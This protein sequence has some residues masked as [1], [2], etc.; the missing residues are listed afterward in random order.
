MNNRF[1]SIIFVLL[2]VY[3]VISACA[4]TKFYTPQ[5][6]AVSY[7]LDGLPADVVFVTVN[8]LRP[9]SDNDDGLANVLKIQLSEA[10]S[11]HPSKQLTNR[12]T[13][14]VDII[15]HRSF[16]TLGNW[17]ASTRFRIRLE[18]SMGKIL[19]QWEAVGSAQHSNTWNLWGDSTAEE[20]SQ[21]S[22]NSAVSD[23]MSYLSQVT[24]H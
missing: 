2:V 17:N 19:G 6:D 22:Y 20:V 15:D 21:E 3:M 8:D 1:R 5:P 4:Q 23:M 24:V 13:V 11:L 10:F 12:Y 16:F 18:N 7:H 9:N 14:T